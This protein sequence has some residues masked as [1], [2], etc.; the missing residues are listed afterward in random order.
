MIRGKMLSTTVYLS[1]EQDLV[2]K[3]ISAITGAPVAYVIRQA[4]DQKLE[5]AYAQ[6]VVRRPDPVEANTPTG[7]VSVEQVKQLIDA[8]VEKALQR[9]NSQVIQQAPPLRK[10]K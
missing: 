7:F 2:L 1:R 10:L 9:G 6:G 8:A 3:Q 5:E 4:I